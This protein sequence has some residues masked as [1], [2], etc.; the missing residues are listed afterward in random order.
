MKWG[1][2]ALA[3]TVSL[4]AAFTTA[5]AQN[6]P[7]K[8]VRVIMS[9]SAGG[10]SDIFMR[11]LADELHKRMGQPFVLENRPG[12]SFNIGARA[13]AEAAPDGYTVCMMSA[14]PVA[15][16]QYLFKTL[17]FDPTAF[18]PI[19]QFFYLTQMMVVSAEL[20][21]R[22]IPE[23]VALSK[24]KPG[25]LSYATAAVPTGVFLERWKTVA[26]IDMVRVP[27]RGGGE[28]VTSLLNGA[29]PVGFYGIANLRELLEGGK[30]H[31]LMVDSLKRSP[32]YPDIPTIEQ[33]TELTFNGRSWFGLFAPPGT[34][35]TIAQRLQVEIAQ[36][37]ARDDFRNKHL[38]ERGLDP[39]AST[40]EEFGRFVNKDRVWS[41]Q[42]I[43]DSGLQP[44]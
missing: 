13:C 9:S 33:A 38:I 28:A 7:S 10:T 3:L 43:K 4:G 37:F 21:V 19:T 34:P 17:P 14:E 26:G 20:N 22:T 8:P 40:P 32:L 42:I 11:V 23:L 35:A 18:V 15:F 5:E 39:V 29:T 25:T 12:G 30:L 1:I 24:A 31:G 16:N 36:I 2:T 44:Q 27:F 6:Y 41:E